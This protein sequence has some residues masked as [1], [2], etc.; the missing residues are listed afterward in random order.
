MAITKKAGILFYCCSL[1]LVSGAGAIG[2]VYTGVGA[3]GR[4][5]LEL[6]S[7]TVDIGI[8]G[9]V[10]VTRTDQV[11]TNHADR[12]L[13]GIYEF[14]LPDGA[15]ITDLVLWIDGKRIPGL[16]LDKQLA[17]GAYDAIVSGRADPALIEQVTP[18]LFRL[19]IFPFP[20]KG[21]RRVELEYMQ[22]LESR[23]GVIRYRFPLA[24]EGDEPVLLEQLILRAE[25]RSQHPIRVAASETGRQRTAIERPDEFTA[26]AFL[27]DERISPQRDYELIVTETAK[28]SPTLLSLAPRGDEYGYFALWLPPVAEL[29][30]AGPVPRN[31]TFLIDVSRSMAGE[32]IAAIEAGLAGALARL[33]KGDFFNLVAFGKTPVSFAESPVEATPENKEAATD[34]AASWEAAGLSDLESALQQALRQRFPG[35]GPNHVVLFTDGPPTHGVTDPGSLGRMAVESGAGGV[36]LFAVGVGD[37]IDRGF[38]RDLTRDRGGSVHFWSGPEIEAGMSAFIEGLAYPVFQPEDLLFS[39]VEVR[40]LL[41]R[42]FTPA[43]AWEELFFAGRYR[44]GGQFAA[45]LRGRIEDQVFEFEYP[46]ELAE[47]GDSQEGED[48]GEILLYEEFDDGIADGWQKAPGTEGVWSVDIDRGVYR[49]EEVDQHK[50]SRAWC[51]VNDSSYRIETRLRFSGLE[52]KVIFSEADRHEAWRLDLIYAQNTARLS[53]GGIFIWGPSF[54]IEKNA[55]YDVRLDIGEG[56][57]DAYVNGNPVYEDAWLGGA[58]PDGV[59]GL[60]TFYAD[61]EFDYVRVT[62]GTGNESASE[63]LTSIAR[64]W[65]YHRVQALE[66]QIALFGPLEELLEDIL[67]LGL[68]YRLVTRATSLFAPEEGIQVNPRVSSQEGGEGRGE[69]DED[70]SSTTAVE[71]SLESASWLGRTFRLSGGIWVDAEFRHSME[72]EAYDPAAGQ[73]GELAA[74]AGLNRNIIVVIGGRAYRLRPTAPP[75]AVLLQNVPNPFNST[76][77]IR[78]LLPAGQDPGPLRVAVYDLLGQVVRVLKPAALPG[79]GGAATWD[80]RDSAGREVSS[81]VYIYRLEGLGTPGRRMMLLR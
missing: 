36:R 81:G 30:S 66:D 65:A 48:R 32:G 59:I 78:F 45:V 50:V 12:V 23:R 63:R 74:F 60:G 67:R 7:V 42:E 22:V 1:L 80:G 25:V 56:L 53:V 31:L 55:W 57:I 16:I 37:E 54:Q 20:A 5:S 34:F 21:S 51:A 71:D 58:T 75:A 18:N 70:W 10:A 40:D 13:E 69:D 26:R 29:A 14:A 41:P 33:G 47:A 46:L 38:L 27:G 64:L 4:E 44:S 3:D 17:R 77:R 15:I 72:V 68:D 2:Y 49:V 39:G 19:S 28:P 79:G 52:A 11:F 24:P 73:P 76:T 35:E 62:R 9:R 8:E 6:T 61:A 43:A